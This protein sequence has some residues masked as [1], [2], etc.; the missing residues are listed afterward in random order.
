MRQVDEAELVVVMRFQISRLPASLRNQLASRHA[1]ARRQ[2][3]Q[4]LAVRLVRAALGRYEILSD[5]PLP[6]GTDLFSRA[7]YREG[8]TGVPVIDEA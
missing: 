6:E 5:A 3:E 1:D 8:G 7:A 4:M 2:A